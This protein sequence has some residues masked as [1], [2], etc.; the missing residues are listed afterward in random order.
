MTKITLGR[1]VILMI[2]TIYANVLII[3]NKDMQIY[4]NIHFN[5][6]TGLFK[7][8]IKFLEN[9]TETVFV[10]YIKNT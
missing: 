7:L 8:S 5:E 1:I 4:T 2:I 9:K 10:N 3:I 6:N